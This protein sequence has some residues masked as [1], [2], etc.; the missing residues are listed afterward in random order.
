MITR[1][2][3]KSIGGLIELQSRLILSRITDAQGSLLL[4]GIAADIY[5]L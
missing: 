4:S 5:C 1:K 3:K 2:N